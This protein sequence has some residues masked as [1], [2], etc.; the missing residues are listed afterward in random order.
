[1]A[2][3]EQTIGAGFERAF[4]DLTDAATNFAD[5]TASLLTNAFGAA[6]DAFVEFVTTGEFQFDKLVNS[7]LEDL[8]RLAFQQAIF[9]ILTGATGGFGAGQAAGTFSSFLTGAAHGGPAETDKPMIVGENGPE[10]FR[11]T[12]PGRIIPNNQIGS[13]PE[14]NVN[15]VNV[16]DP[17]EIAVAMASP[18][19]ERTIINVVRRN[20]TAI[21]SALGA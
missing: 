8:A 6:E 9:G 17:E 11:P 19:G 14:V 3:T 13:S 5:I 7:I 18:E 10:I 2:E 4:L 15:I 12:E 20:R 16:T 1:M 21:Q